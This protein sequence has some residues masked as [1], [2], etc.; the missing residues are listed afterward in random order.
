MDT[1][2]VGVEVEIDLEGVD[3]PGFRDPTVLLGTNHGI[4]D[5]GLAAAEMADQELLGVPGFKEEIKGTTLDVLALRHRPDIA[6]VVTDEVV[7]TWAQGAI[8]FDPRKYN[9]WIFNYNNGVCY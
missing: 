5:V 1:C 8:W 9:T 3:N 2:Q 7:D 4:P 6:A